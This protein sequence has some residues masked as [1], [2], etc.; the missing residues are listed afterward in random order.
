[1]SDFSQQ[2]KNRFRAQTEENLTFKSSIFDRR[3][4]PNPNPKE[5]Q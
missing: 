3:D 5:M 4:L 1:M 2:A